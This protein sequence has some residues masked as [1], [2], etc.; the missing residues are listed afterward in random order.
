M[1]D[2]KKQTVR[3]LRKMKKDGNRITMITAYDAPTARFAEAGGVDM[4]L[5]GD[6]LG[7]SC[8]GYSDTIPVT[9]D[10]MIL[11]CKAVRRGAPNTFIVGDMPFMSYHLSAEQALTNA[12]RF[13]QEANCDCVKLETDHSTIPVVKRL[14]D[15]GIPVCAHIGLL[16]Q[17]LKISGSYRVQGRSEDAAAALLADA[18]ALQEAGAFC[19]VFECLPKM[20]AKQITGALEI[21]TIGIGAGMYCDGQVQVIADLVGF[22]TDFL[23]KHAKR[24]AELGKGM[25]NAIAEYVADVK[26]GKFPA[27]ENSFD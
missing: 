2:I 11:H 10:D 26:A 15:A 1:Q 17:S 5:V 16:P 9:M 23:P 18:K 27:D 3:S 20:L 7:M 6:S 22:F 8:L 4:I 24:Y 19:I 14:V 12:A 25:T 21:P 13:M